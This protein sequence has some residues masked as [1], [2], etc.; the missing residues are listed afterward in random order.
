VPG[1]L[2]AKQSGHDITKGVQWFNPSAFAPPQPWQWGN[3]QPDSVWGPGS[4]DWDMSLQKGFRIPIRGS[5]TTRLVF[6][7]DFF[8]AFNHF[9]LSNPSATVADA[10]DGGSAITT[11]GEVYGGSGNRTIQL[12]LKFD[13]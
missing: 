9:N 3:S 7:A 5:E 10:R 2:Y 13:F 6:R 1:N 4:W 12:G 8:D 11:T